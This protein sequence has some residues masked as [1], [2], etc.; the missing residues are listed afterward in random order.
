L[1]KLGKFL[2]F[3]REKFSDKMAHSLIR[4]FLLLFLLSNVRS[5]NIEDT[6]IRDLLRNYSPLVR[7]SLNYT[8]VI[9]ILFDVSIVQITNLDEKNQMMSIN[10]WLTMTWMDNKLSWKPSNY[11]GVEEIRLPSSSVWKPVIYNSISL[12]NY[13]LSLIMNYYS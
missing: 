2:I 4:S 5:Q 8:D 9:N 12:N 7:P 13:L 6:L 1:N 3:W 10:A 11:E